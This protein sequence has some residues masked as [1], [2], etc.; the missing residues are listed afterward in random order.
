MGEKK[1]RAS[2]GSWSL[3]LGLGS[4]VALLLPAFGDYV[5][6]ICVLGA[7]VTGYV[8]IVDFEKKKTPH[9]WGAVFGIM[10]GAIALFLIV[11]MRMSTVR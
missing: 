5:A 2:A 6:I 11:I 3:A 7:F 4:G 8:G 9:R 1:A 10:C